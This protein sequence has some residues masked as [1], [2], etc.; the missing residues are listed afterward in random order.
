MCSVSSIS[1][2]VSLDMGKT[3]YPQKIMN[4]TEIP[5][6]IVRTSKL[7]EGLGGVT[8]THLQLPVLVLLRG[9]SLDAVD[10]NMTYFKNSK[11]ATNTM[12]VFRVL[13]I[14]TF[15]KRVPKGTSRCSSRSRTSRL[16]PLPPLPRRLVRCA[17]GTWSST[18]LEL[19]THTN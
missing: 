8:M 11:I 6:T 2:Q 19:S 4:D 17:V 9:S 1:L 10:G 18:L 13:A 14:V 12:R 7:P 5:N 15:L 3:I 16:Y